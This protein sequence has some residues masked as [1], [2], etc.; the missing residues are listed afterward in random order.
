[1]TLGYHAPLPPMRTGVA[2]YAVNL[3]DALRTLMRVEVEPRECDLRMYHLGNNQL[4]GAIYDRA[5]AEPGIVVLHDAVLHHFLLG[6]LDERAYVDEFVYNYGEWSRDLAFQLWRNRARSG[7]DARYFEYPMLKRIAE[8]SRAIVVHNPAAAAIVRRHA[9]AARIVEI[10]HVFLASEPVPAHETEPLRKSWGFPSG[11]AIF[12]LFGHL[13]E[14]KRVLPVL[15]VFGKLAGGL[16][17]GLLVAGECASADLARAMRPL[18][19]H[20]RLR[21][22]GY[23]AE[24][25]FPRASLAVDACINLRYPS[26]GETSGISIR[27]MGAGKPVIVTESAENSRFPEDAC[28]R[29]EPGAAEE[30]ML[31][32]YVTWL[33][34]FPEAGRQIGAR[35]QRHILGQ[36]APSRVAR[37]YQHALEIGL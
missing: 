18:L 9:P 13:R 29:V 31:A 33:A 6:R 19:D 8:R 27:M 11:A 17:I 4:H 1:V 15:R 30:S 20:P 10:P 37:L 28:L 32:E 3:L 7:L 12:G 35:A 21:R 34:K 14:S 22:V 5:L 24:R 26:A 23:I 25:D 36:H 2:D 16:N